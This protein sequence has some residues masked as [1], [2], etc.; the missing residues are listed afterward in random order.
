MRHEVGE[1]SSR[2][3]GGDDGVMDD[4]IAAAAAGDPALVPTTPRLTLES[5]RIAFAAEAARRE[6]RVVASPG[7]TAAWPPC[8]GR[9]RST[10]AELAAG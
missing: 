9:R 6:D 8:P 1:V 10:A 4:F 7:L 3:G 5:H 2:H